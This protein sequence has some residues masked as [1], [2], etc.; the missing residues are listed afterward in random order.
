MTWLPL[1]VAVAGTVWAV[2]ALGPAIAPRLS[3]ETRT[4]L[5][6]VLVPAVLAAIVVDAVVSG[7]DDGRLAV[8]AGFVAG[9]GLLLARAPLPLAAAVGCAIALVL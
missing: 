5:L 2:R 4:R 9:A 7:A 6:T 1:I 8:P 3:D